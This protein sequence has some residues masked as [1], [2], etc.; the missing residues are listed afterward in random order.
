MSLVFVQLR[1]F[2]FRMRH[3]AARFKFWV[4]GVLR[5]A[6]L[7]S[8]RPALVCHGII[9]ASLG[10]QRPVFLTLIGKMLLFLRSFIAKWRVQTLSLAIFDLANQSLM[11]ALPTLSSGNP[12]LRH[13]V[14]PSVDLTISN[15]LA[16]AD[17]IPIQ[18]TWAS[19][20]TQ[21]Q[22]NSKSSVHP[23]ARLT[24]VWTSPLFNHASL[25]VDWLPSK[26]RRGHWQWS[27]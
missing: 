4:P 15:W 23:Q 26:H 9:F 24:Q 12:I 3:V 11:F 16:K 17:S 22:L 5:K 10:K 21:R 14:R 7:S 6:P 8:V 2:R 13:Q 20:L 25:L 1:P 19:L 18:L 27:H